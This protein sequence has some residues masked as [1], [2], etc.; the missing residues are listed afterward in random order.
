MQDTSHVEQHVNFLRPQ[1]ALDLCCHVL[2]LLLAGDVARHRE[3]PVRAI[4]LLQ[5]LESW[6]NARTGGSNDGALAAPP[7]ELSPKAQPNA[8][9]RAGYYHELWQY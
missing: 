4:L 9:R 8:T 6:R 7:K 1:V 3:H 5:R 2:A